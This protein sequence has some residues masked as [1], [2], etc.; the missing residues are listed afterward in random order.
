[1]RTCA[2]I[3][4]RRSRIRCVSRLGQPRALDGL[5]NHSRLPPR[6]QQSSA[7]RRSLLTACVVASIGSAAVGCGDDDAPPPAP[8]AGASGAGGA[9]GAA[10]GQAGSA[11]GAPAPVACGTAMCTPRPNPITQLIGAVA[12]GVPLPIPTPVACCLDATGG[13]CGVAAMTGATCEAYATPD[14]RC[15]SVNLGALG[16]VAGG[17]GN[18]GAGCCTVS[19]QCGL[20]GAIFGRG[21]VENNEARSMLGAVPFIGTL[22]AVPPAGACDMPLD[23][24]GVDDAGL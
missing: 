8:V 15:P 14:S 18:F 3:R 5:M 23:D 1:M 24:G 7:L 13:V 12:P 19:G 16:A 17:L 11:A 22:I 9:S 20:D 21:C 10:G 6:F 2:L 4:A